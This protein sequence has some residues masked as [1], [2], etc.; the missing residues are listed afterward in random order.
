VPEVTAQLVEWVDDFEAEAE[1]A[2]LQADRHSRT[3][4]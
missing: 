4:D 3:K 1:A 2:E